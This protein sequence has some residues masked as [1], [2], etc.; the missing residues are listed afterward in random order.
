M[1]LKDKTY[2]VTG[3]AQ[4]IGLGICKSILEAGGKVSMIDINEDQLNDSAFE[5]EKKYQTI[6][7]NTNDYK[8]GVQAFLEKR[9]PNFKGN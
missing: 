1:I 7:A 3:A 2:L 5:L 8:E 6:A 4:G 9:K